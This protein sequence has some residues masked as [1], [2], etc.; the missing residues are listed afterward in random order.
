MAVIEPKNG[1][2]RTPANGRYASEIESLHAWRAHNP[3]TVSDVSDVDHSAAG[4]NE[5]RASNAS[6][7]DAD[8]D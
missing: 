7:G 5:T 1:L 2:I 3:A 4:R 8:K 6:T